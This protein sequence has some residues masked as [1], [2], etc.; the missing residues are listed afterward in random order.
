MFSST[1]Q[2]V[3]ILNRAAVLSTFKD[4]LPNKLS[5]TAGWCGEGSLGPEEYRTILA[6]SIFAPCP[7]GNYNQ[8]TFRLYEALEAGTIPIV[9]RSTNAQPY[10]YWKCIFGTE[11]SI[12]IVENWE[13]AKSSRNN[14]VGRST[15]TDITSV[16]ST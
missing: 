13:D 9:L 12:I 15:C 4:F 10:D 1:C 3:G 11:D 5:Y 16:A 2:S 8:E 6:M 7:P 14:T